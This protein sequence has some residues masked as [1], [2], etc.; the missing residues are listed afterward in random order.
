MYQVVIAMSCTLT[1]MLVGL[2]HVG[3]YTLMGFFLVT[4]NPFINVIRSQLNYRASF[5]L[6]SDTTLATGAP[7]LRILSLSYL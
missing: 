6:R 3:F 2:C 1:L 7:L 4:G 5:G